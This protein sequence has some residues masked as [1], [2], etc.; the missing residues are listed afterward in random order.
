[1]LVLLALACAPAGPLDTGDPAPL[2]VDGDV[3]QVRGSDSTPWSECAEDPDCVECIDFGAD[4]YRWGANGRGDEWSGLGEY[5]IAV[6]IDGDRIEVD[7]L[8][9]S[10][11]VHG[12]WATLY[13]DGG[14]YFATTRRCTIP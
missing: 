11:E 7:G 4:V 9:M 12:D 10:F 13:P 14:D 5:P 8:G 3:W 6:A 1:M 2:T